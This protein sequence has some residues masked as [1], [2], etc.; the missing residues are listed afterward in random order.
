MK[1]AFL[2]AGQGAQ[3][4]GMG[5]DFYEQSVAYKTAVDSIGI[6]NNIK[7]IM[8]EGPEEVLMQ[9]ENTQPCMA[10]FA[11]GVVAALKEAGIT[12]DA[13]CGLS[14]GEYGALYASG[15]ISAKQYVDIVS[16]RGKVMAE[17][18]KGK[19]CAMSA[20]VGLDAEKVEEAVEKA[21]LDGYVTVA[22]YNCPGQYVIC[23]EEVPVSKCEEICVE[24]GAKQAIRLKVSGPFHTKYMSEAGQKLRAELDKIDFKEPAVPV[25]L[26]V[27]GTYYAGECMQDNLEKQIQS[28]VHFEDEI[29]QLINDGYE[30]FIEIGPGKTLAGF[31]KRTAK[32]MSVAV[33][34]YSIDSVSDLDKLLN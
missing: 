9:T 17:A 30:R 25:L 22:N 12:P 21:S 3:H 33:S 34:T 20:V 7:M 24:M 11:V 6:D 14:I 28:G 31:V 2:F 15:M 1:T 29:V 10:V 8:D 26:N 4:V 18:A 27:T 16:Y 23:G 13:V 5:T 32:K 19:Q